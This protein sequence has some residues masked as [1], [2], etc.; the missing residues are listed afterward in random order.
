MVNW[1]K[2]TSLDLL[3]CDQL[4]N[5]PLKRLV[6]IVHLDD[7]ISLEKS[8]VVWY[9]R[10]KS[11]I[12]TTK[13]HDNVVLLKLSSTSVATDEVKTILNVDNR[14]CNIFL[15]N[16]LSDSFIQHVPLSW[17]ESDWGSTEELVTLVVDLVLRDSLWL[18][19]LEKFLS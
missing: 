17:L 6:R 15:V 2:G 11:F 14:N 5:N 18:V 4:I 13:S 1:R 16:D 3:T 12:S 10:V 19:L 7:K 9:I 8:M